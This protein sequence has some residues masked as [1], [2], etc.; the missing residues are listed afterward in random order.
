MSFRVYPLSFLAFVATCHA[1]GFMANP[2]TCDGATPPDNVGVTS[3]MASSTSA[4]P[5]AATPTRGLAVSIIAPTSCGSAK[6]P[7][8]HAFRRHVRPKK[9]HEIQLLGEVSE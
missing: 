1:F 9:R 6:E 5:T 2:S 7:L 4:A 3:S 8:K